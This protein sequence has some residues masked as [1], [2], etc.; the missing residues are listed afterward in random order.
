MLAGMDPITSKIEELGYILPPP[1]KPAGSYLPW[2]RSG[3]LL[4][5]SGVL[6]MREGELTHTGAVGSEQT[7]ESAQEAARI[8]LLN[9]LAIA[10]GALG[11]FDPIQQVLFVNGYVYGIAGFDKSPAVINGASDMLTEV[12]GE[13]GQHARAAVAVAGLPLNAS[14]E[15][16]LTLEV[17]EP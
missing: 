6:P 17:A 10:H 9:A 16:Q 15:L 4:Y 13:R 7:V 8:C 5:I 2:K 1:P 12:L 11:S 3:K 14:V